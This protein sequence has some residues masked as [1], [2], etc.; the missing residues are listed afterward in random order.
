MSWSEPADSDIDFTAEPE[1]VTLTHDHTTNVFHTIQVPDY[2]HLALLFSMTMLTLIFCYLPIQYRA[3]LRD[4][5]T[6][7]S[8]VAT[9]LDH[10]GVDILYESSTALVL[11]VD[12]IVL[13]PIEDALTQ[14]I[15]IISGVLLAI[16][17]LILVTI[18]SVF[19]VCKRKRKRSRHPSSQVTDDTSPE[20]HTSIIK[21]IWTTSRGL[22]TS[23]FHNNKVYKEKDPEYQKSGNLEHHHNLL[24]QSQNHKPLLRHTSRA[25]VSTQST[26]SQGS[27]E[28]DRSGTKKYIALN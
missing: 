15:G 19:V 17:F 12:K 26:A 13:P 23:T 2:S 3:A 6:I 24:V 9:Q 11:R 14:K 21:P 16:I 25:T 18:F 4:N 5:N 8:C 27:W 10:N 22:V 1:I 28:E 20:Q 7:I